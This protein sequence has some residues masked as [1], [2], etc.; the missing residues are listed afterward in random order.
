VHGSLVEWARRGVLLLNTS[1]DG[2]GGPGR[3]PREEGLGDA[4]RCVAGGGGE[5]ASP[6]VYLLW[7]AHAQAKAPLIE[8]TAREHGRDALI[9][10]ANHPSPLSALRPPCLSWAAATSPRPGTGW[11]CVAIPACFES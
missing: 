6:S 7:G 5:D 11:P 8:H 10:Q 1:L 2:R 9:L 4:D 3:Q